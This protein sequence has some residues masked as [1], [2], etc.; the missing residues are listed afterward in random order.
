LGDP[1]LAILKEKS[2]QSLQPEQW[3]ECADLLEMALGEET[4]LLRV[5]E[6]P[7]LL[8]Y[9]WDKRLQYIDRPDPGEMEALL[10]LD[11]DLSAARDL[12][13]QPERY[14][15]LLKRTRGSGDQA[16]TEQL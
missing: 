7:Q 5:R 6:E 12:L 16:Q 10:D 3:S 2:S 11:P 15:I 13:E 8:R 9:L 1:L 14:Q 4:D